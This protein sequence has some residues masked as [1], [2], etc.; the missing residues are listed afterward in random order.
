L[1]DL[2][3]LTTSKRRE[4]REGRERGRGKERKRGGRRGGRRG[5]G[6][7]GG[8]RGKGR[9]GNLEFYHLLL[10]TLTTAGSRTD[11]QFEFRTPSVVA[12]GVDTRASS[13][14]SPCCRAYQ[15]LKHVI[16]PG[17]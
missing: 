9:G 5:R 2:R 11:Q 16:C 3:K 13:A 6:L 8:R 12:V 15:T 1:L 17:R 7:R 10:S 4:E 14:A